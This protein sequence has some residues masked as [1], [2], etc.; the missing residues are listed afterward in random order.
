MVFVAFVVL[1]SVILLIFLK[2]RRDRYCLFKAVLFMLL[3]SVIANINLYHNYTQSLVP[4]LYDGISISNVIAY[5]FFP[6]HSWS[7]EFFKRRFDQSVIVSVILLIALIGLYLVEQ[8][9]G[10]KI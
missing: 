5:Q 9:K 6:D 1:I 8:F 3:A 7:I 2:G 10:K 4:G